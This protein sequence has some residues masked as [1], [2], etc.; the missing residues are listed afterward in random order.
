MHRLCLSNSQNSPIGTLGTEN[1]CS[2]IANNGPDD[3]N[4]N[5]TKGSSHKSLIYNLWSWYCSEIEIWNLHYLLFI[6]TQHKWRP[7]P[8]PQTLLSIS[9]RLEWKIGKLIHELIKDWIS[10][11]IACK[12]NITWLLHPHKRS[13]SSGLVNKF[14]K[15]NL[16]QLLTWRAKGSSLQTKY[17]V[18][19]LVPRYVF[20]LIFLLFHVVL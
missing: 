4:Q 10:R 2:I 18:K 8:P 9:T 16:A 11:D 12:Y 7:H 20:S 13:G 15:N 3:Q 5:F 6:D 14:E 17:G 1:Y 19:I